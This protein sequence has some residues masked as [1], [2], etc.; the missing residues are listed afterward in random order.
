MNIFQNLMKSKKSK[1]W[2]MKNCINILQNWKKSS[3]FIKEK[4]ILKNNNEKV[5]E[6]NNKKKVF[7]VAFLL[8]LIQMKDKKRSN[9]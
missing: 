1:N 6:H 4:K 2:K 5:N 7:L 8:A 9:W 3:Q